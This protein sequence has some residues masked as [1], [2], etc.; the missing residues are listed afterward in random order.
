MQTTLVKKVLLSILAALILRKFQKILL[1]SASGE[2]RSSAKILLKMGA[3]GE[4]V[5]A[6][7]GVKGGTKVAQAAAKAVAEK[8]GAC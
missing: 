5:L 8:A 3:S 2:L 7:L 6:R 4:K 1:N